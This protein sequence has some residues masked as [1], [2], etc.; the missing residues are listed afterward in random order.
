[1][2]G[3]CR[4]AEQ[5]GSFGVDVQIAKLAVD[6]EE[7]VTDL[8]H[9]RGDSRPS[10]LSLDARAAFAFE[11]VVRRDL[12][13][14]LRRDVPEIAL[15]VKRPSSR[16]GDDPRLVLD[17]DRSTTRRNQTILKRKRELVS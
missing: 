1:D 12:R 14:S 10:L 9:R 2:D 7:R 5:R 15:G 6:R 11:S 8:F 3:V 16:G 4:L 17:P 13:H